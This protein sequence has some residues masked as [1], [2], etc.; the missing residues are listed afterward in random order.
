M[1]LR[2]VLLE[3]SFKP[4][5]QRMIRPKVTCL[6]GV[7]IIAIDR[8]VPR[9]RLISKGNNLYE[10]SQI[11]RKRCCVF[12]KCRNALRTIDDYIIFN[13][14]SISFNLCLVTEHCDAIMIEWEVLVFSW[15]FEDRKSVV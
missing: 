5:H 6:N 11:F 14:Q 10:Y 1:I 2:E 15:V 8:N 13:T 3:L 12:E 7:L 9:E 4:E